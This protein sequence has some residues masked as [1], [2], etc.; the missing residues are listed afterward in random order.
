MQTSV[1]VVSLSWS[2]INGLKE[3]NL[4]RIPLQRLF[5]GIRTI[6]V[7]FFSFTQLSIYEIIFIL[8]E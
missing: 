7:F 6:Y 4:C 8:I 1:S 5:L 2:F 3:T